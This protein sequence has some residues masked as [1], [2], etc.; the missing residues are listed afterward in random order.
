MVT[1]HESVHLREALAPADH[2]F[3]A[4]QAVIDPC[5]AQELCAS[6]QYRMLDLGLFDHAV[7]PD[8]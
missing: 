8:G 5:N 7:R 1:E 2:D 4:Y 3:S 6:E